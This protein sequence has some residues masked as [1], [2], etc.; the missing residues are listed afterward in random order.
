MTETE[1]EK[2]EEHTEKTEAH[3]PLAD[4]KREAIL[5]QIE[6][7]ERFANMLEAETAWFRTEITYLRS[8]LEQ[9]R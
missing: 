7:L 2:I 3:I 4:T 6:I 5:L 1:P 8:M 9:Q